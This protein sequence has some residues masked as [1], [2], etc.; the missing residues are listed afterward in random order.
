M[1]NGNVEIVIAWGPIIHMTCIQ[2]QRQ[3]FIAIWSAGPACVPVELYIL[4]LFLL[5]IYAYL[6]IFNVPTWR[7]NFIVS[8]CT[9]LIFTKFSQMIDL[10]PSFSDG[11]GDVAT[12]T[13]CAT[14]SAKSAYLTFI[15]HTDIPKR[16]GGSKQRC[17][18][19]K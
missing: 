8:L 17:E 18:K 6:F 11:S 12:A 15:N 3:S 9:E 13:N 19:L 1:N 7:I 4:L 16:T 2:S 5:F 10:H 14:K